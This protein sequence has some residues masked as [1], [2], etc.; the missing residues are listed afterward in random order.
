MSLQRIAPELPVTDLSKSLDY[1]KTKLGF[2]VVSEFPDGSYAVVQRDDVAIHLFED[3]TNTQPVGVHIFTAA[4][5]DLHEE[6]RTAG[7]MVTQAVERKPWG[8]RDFRVTDPF[9]NQIKF[10]E[11]SA[12]D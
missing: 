6:L 10:T 7:A 8:N 9:G 3:G 1:Y 12:E 5:D 4:L 11:P 2:D